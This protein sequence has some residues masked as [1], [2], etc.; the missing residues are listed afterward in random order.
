MIERLHDPAFRGFASDN[1]SGVLPEILEALALVNGGHQKAYGEDVYTAA[2]GDLV[3]EQFGPDASIYPVFNGTGAN[4]VSLDLVTPRWG[5][6]VCA[7]SAHI[8]VDECGAPEK[9]AGLKLLPVDTPE[10]KLTPE[11]VEQVAWGFDDE[12]HAQ[13]S[14][15]SIT[16]STELGTL[17][18]VEE[19]RAL[20][21]HAHSLGMRLHLDGARLFI[22]AAALGVSLKELTTDAGVDVLSLGGTKHGLMGAEAVVVLDPDILD[23][24]KRALFIRKL[25]AQLNSKMRFTSAQL[26]TIL[27]GDLWRRGS[28]HAIAM[29][30]RLSDAVRDVDGV[31]VTREPEANAVFAILP[32]AVTER[33]QQRYP[34][35]VWDEATG[36][37]RWMCSFDTTEDDVD[38][39]AA[40]LREEMAT[41]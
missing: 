13:A 9:I 21:D 37:V 22:G 10:G 2:L 33:L 20:A 30:K 29:A 19:I 15:V 17:Y 12:H 4:I 39:F 36:E 6:V 28:E 3:T 41:A 31:T 23:H 7:R 16:Q 26:M 25:D 24:P 34:F 32:E 14:V 1:Y 11:L 5:A 38:A 18:T 8:N 27:S 35:Y 40:A